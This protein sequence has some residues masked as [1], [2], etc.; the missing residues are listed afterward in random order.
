MRRV[1]G[2][3][4]APAFWSA[5][6]EQRIAQDLTWSKLNR[7]IGWLSPATLTRMRRGGEIG[8]HAV[9]PFIQWLGRTPESFT[10]GAE[11]VEGE[12]LPDPGAGRWRWYWHIP[13]LHDALES[14]RVE[15]DMAWSEVADALGEHI[16]ELKHLERSRY[17]TSMRL[18]MRAA[19]WLGRSATSFMWE[20]DGRG[21][22][23][24]GRR[25]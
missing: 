23:W 18:A 3:F 14:R 20:H 19:R 5:L 2:D 11:D 17:G 16:N 4:D 6:D 25:A 21:L 9:L 22:P 15:L 10:A 13:E 12:L 7:D 1:P 8:C 24:S